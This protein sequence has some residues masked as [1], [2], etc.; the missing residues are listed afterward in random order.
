MV[1]V[2]RVN[3]RLVR[4]TSQSPQTTQQK[5]QAK[6][7]NLRAQQIRQQQINAEA[8]RI[9]KELLNNNFGGS[10][11]EF[12]K[13][14]NSIKSANPEVAAQLK[15]NPKTIQQELNKRI[16]SIESDILKSKR[17]EDKFD[18][19]DDK[20]NEEGERARQQGLTKGLN[21]LKQG[22][23]LTVGN[24]NK[25]AS[26][27]RSNARK[28]QK[29][30]DRQKKI[31][32]SSKTK[33]S[34]IIKTE[35][36]K[37]FNTN[38]PDFK[39]KGETVSSIKNTQTNKTISSKQA[40]AFTTTKSGIKVFIS[41]DAPGETKFGGQAVLSKIELNQVQRL[42]R[43][44]DKAKKGNLKSGDVKGLTGK[45]M[46]FLVNL[47]QVSALK[48]KEDLDTSKLFNALSKTRFVD[49]PSQVQAFKIAANQIIKQEGGQALS[50]SA[51]IKVFEAKLK[52][53]EKVKKEFAK[54]GVETAVKRL[55]TT[56][57]VQPNISKILSTAQQQKVI[58]LVQT[59]QTLTPTQRTQY[60]NIILNQGKKLNKQQ[61]SFFKKASLVVPAFIYGRNLRL[62][63]EGG[64]N[65][66]FL[67]DVKEVKREFTKATFGLGLEI[68]TL[69]GTAARNSLA[70]SYDY[71]KSITVEAQKGNFVLDDDIKKLGTTILK[72][73]KDIIQA[74]IK[75]TKFVKENPVL[76][77][78]IVSSVAKK[79][80]VNLKTKFIKDPVE[81]TIGALL[82]VGTP[83]KIPKFVK[84]SYIKFSPRGTKLPFQNAVEFT[85][86]KKIGKLQGTKQDLFHISPAKIENFFAKKGIGRQDYIKVI[87]GTGAGIE[88]QYYWAREK[89]DLTPF[90]KA[91][92]SAKTTA[93]K[94]KVVD[95][96]RK[97]IGKQFKLNSAQINKRN[98]EL[99]E[100][101]FYAAP[102]RVYTTFGNSTLI[103]F[104]NT[105]IEKFPRSIQ[106]RINNIP[107]LS[108]SQRT[109]LRID[110]NKHISANKNKFFVGPKT[111]SGLGPEL[112]VVAAVGSKF[113][114]RKTL[115][116]QVFRFLGITKGSKV[117][118]LPT[119]DAF[120]QV[121]EV[122]FKQQKIITNKSFMKRFINFFSETLEK[123]KNGAKIKPSELKQAIIKFIKDK[124]LSKPSKSIT[125]KPKKK[126]TS[127]QKKLIKQ[128]R[129]QLEKEFIRRKGIKVT[130]RKTKLKRAP[131]P[132][133]RTPTKPKR[134]PKITR[135]PPKPKRA[136]PK[137]VRDV[138]TPRVPKITR[139]PPKPKRTPPKLP[140][141]D[142]DSNV[143]NNRIILIQGLYRERKNRNLP[144]G[145]KN[146]VVTKILNIRTTKNRAL[147]QIADLADRRTVRSITTKIVGVTDKK[148]QDIVRP[149]V[150]NKFS[151]KKS[152]NTP[153]L[154]LVEKTKFISDTRGEKRELAKSRRIKKGKVVSKVKDKKKVVKK[155]KSIKRKKAKK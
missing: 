46:T 55:P 16:T 49:T 112:E 20:P 155:S 128:K 148:M 146:P 100:F 139:Q 119:A 153:V 126:L 11:Q 62:R 34:F 36:G 131:K 78:I 136:P 57:L 117:A 50:Q 99:G 77:A 54:K 116:T 8:Q 61:W 102:G 82:L 89:I 108:I 98:K 70:A 104:S 28:E 33:T 19:R 137:P 24:I 83:L 87:E 80:G 6:R 32:K 60:N 103:K 150:L 134:A 132:V 97:R 115:T 79:T 42:V 85:D 72:G 7:S 66:P 12:N 4:D 105:I 69:L 154:V 10:I 76:S 41:S 106:N 120:I 48:G 111:A 94:K 31:T 74:T 35:S 149:K 75:I 1:D 5:I 38:N 95:S 63:A 18:D 135:Q 30:K 92:K 26:D 56:P 67:N 51:N 130:K 27:L 73:S 9:D 40:P 47:N 17:R 84:Q 144:A 124:K 96:L 142:F 141:P 90:E 21:R 29:A 91:F 110:M 93:K 43:L 15:F 14:Y 2:K 118:Y 133:R 147:K 152:K 125:T 114:A 88:R 109:K 86:Y 68:G 123:I 37:T 145:K 3:G 101:A 58:N 121:A 107:K 65:N 138:T 13:Q 113:K 64:E 71:G 129:T 52:K 122:A 81:T 53:I 59:R 22:E 44:E 39:P 140:K 25:F 127:K 23:F 143:Y 45:Q 151:R